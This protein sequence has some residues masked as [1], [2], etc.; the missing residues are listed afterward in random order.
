MADASKSPIDLTDTL[1]IAHYN[2]GFTLLRQGRDE[3]GIAALKVFLGLAVRLAGRVPEVAGRPQEA[4]C[5]AIGGAVAQSSPARKASR[6]TAS[7]R[8]DR[9]FSI[10]R[11]QP[12]SGCERGLAR[13]RRREYG[14]GMA[15]RTRTGSRCST[16][17]TSTALRMNTRAA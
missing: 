7:S 12:G 13:R 14:G 6:P 9:I 8:I 10:I 5:A 2:L 15:S 11:G 3:D 1:P 4:L 17:W 16:S